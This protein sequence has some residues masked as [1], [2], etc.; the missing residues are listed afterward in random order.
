M[1]GISPIF[2]NRAT[3]LQKRKFPHAQKKG[4]NSLKLRH[5]KKEKKGQTIPHE[6]VP[7][8]LDMY[9]LLHKMINPTSNFT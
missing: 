3:P 2:E 9:F 6:K 5:L 7:L 8:L 1:W 4:T